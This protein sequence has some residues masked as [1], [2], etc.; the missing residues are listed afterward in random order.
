MGVCEGLPGARQL[1]S[2]TCPSGRE[3]LVPPQDQS[4]CFRRAAPT[5]APRKWD[6]GPHPCTSSP[7]PSRSRPERELIVEEITGLKYTH[8][9]VTVPGTQAVSF[10]PGQ[11]SLTNPRFSQGPLLP[12]PEIIP[13]FSN[14]PDLIKGRGRAGWC[15]RDSVRDRQG[16]RSRS[17]RTRCWSRDCTPHPA[18]F[19]PLRPRGPRPTPALR[20]SGSS[21]GRLPPG[22][23]AAFPREGRASAS[24]RSLNSPRPEVCGASRDD[25]WA[26]P[27][28]SGPTAPERL[29]SHPGAVGH[30]AGARRK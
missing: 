7:P 22:K 14:C 24:G 9:T 21:R 30:D 25:I 13:V 3:T 29:P 8:P 11:P 20:A 18:A 17:A 6:F 4:P 23:V 19:R 26:G 10:V 27:E 5:L 28:D 2:N 15:L 12:Q 16:H 1:E